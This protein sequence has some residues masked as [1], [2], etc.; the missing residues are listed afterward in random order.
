MDVRDHERRQLS[1][2]LPRSGARFSSSRIIAG[3]LS[4]SP[5]SRTCPNIYIFT[6]DSIG[7]GEDGPTH[8]PVET[9]S[10]GSRHARTARCHRPA[11][12]EEEPRV[13]SLPQ[14]RERTDPLA[15]LDAPEVPMLNE[16]DVKHAARR[17]LGAAVTSRRKESGKL[18]LILLSCGS[19]LQHAFA[20][21]KELGDGTFASS[22]C[23][24][25]NASNASPKISQRSLPA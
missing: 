23:P 17:R 15:R 3:P 24:A 19:E 12:P 8:E 10:S 2:Y 1:R 5:R 16:I 20:A 21:A 7:V 11:D 4:A 22:R 14:R 13:R 6:H 25:S 9:V 18:E